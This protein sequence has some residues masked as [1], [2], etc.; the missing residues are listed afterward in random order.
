M[1][2]ENDDESDD[3]LMRFEGKGGVTLTMMTAPSETF[4]D[5]NENIE[6]LITGWEKQIYAIFNEDVVERMIRN[7]IDTN[8]EIYGEK[9]AAFL[10]I[11]LMMQKAMEA[12]EK[13]QEENNI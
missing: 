8:G 4:G 3:V 7:A 6:P 2:T 13:Y 10:P 11:T 9:A 12:A 5:D 1:S